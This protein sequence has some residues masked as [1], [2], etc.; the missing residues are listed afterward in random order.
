MFTANSNFVCPS[1]QT[2]TRRFDAMAEEVS[3]DLKNEVIK[4][5]TDA[6]HKTIRIVSDHGTSS[7]VFR[8]KKNVVVAS[9]TTLDFEIKTDTIAL[10]KSDG[11]QTGF[12]IRS[13][14]KDTLEDIYGY[15]WTKQL[16]P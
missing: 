8:T 5:V 10:I 1:R 12:K 3:K 4:D 7:D 16:M 2:I 13:D 11:S 14:V 6:G 9:R 15:L